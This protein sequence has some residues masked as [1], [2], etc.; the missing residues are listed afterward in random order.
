MND[1]HLAALQLRVCTNDYGTL[2]TNQ[3]STGRSTVDK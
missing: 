3:V 2:L 1:R